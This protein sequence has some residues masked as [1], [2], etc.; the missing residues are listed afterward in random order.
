VQLLREAGHAAELA[1]QPGTEH[2]YP[3]NYVEVL[4]KAFQYVLSDEPPNPQE[5]K[6]EQPAESAPQE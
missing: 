5:P 1:M 6:A 2:E 4:T 3:R